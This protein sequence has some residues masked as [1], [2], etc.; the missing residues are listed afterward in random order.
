VQSQP[1]PTPPQEIN[2]ALLEAILGKDRKKQ[3]EAAGRVFN[4]ILPYLYPQVEA[5]LK[6]NGYLKTLM[7]DDIFGNVPKTPPELLEK[8]GLSD[9]PITEISPLDFF[10]RLATADL[11]PKWGDVAESALGMIFE[12][13]YGWKPGDVTKMTPEQMLLALESAI[14]YTPPGKPDI[15]TLTK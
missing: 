14:E 13:R 15:W 2:D 12:L 6:I 5:Q 10:G 11:G 4:W 3:W 9:R 1:V 8:L 7:G